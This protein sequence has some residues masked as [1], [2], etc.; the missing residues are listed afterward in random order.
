MKPS[1]HDLDIHVVY[2]DC[3]KGHMTPPPLSMNATG[4]N[5]HIWRAPTPTYIASIPVSAA[6][7]SS[8]FKQGRLHGSQTLLTYTQGDIA[9]KTPMEMERSLSSEKHMRCVCVAVFV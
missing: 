6:L 4:I 5:V 2:K 8:D 1:L 7:C 9:M 3:K